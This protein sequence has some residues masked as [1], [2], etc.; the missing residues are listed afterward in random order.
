MSMLG[1]IGYGYVGRSVEYGFVDYDRQRG[2]EP[3]HKALIHDKYKS[4]LSL[5]EVAD[6]SEIIFLCLPTP[7]DEERLRIDLSITD[8]VLA[9][10]AP[11][12]AG[13]GKIIVIKS[14][15]VPGTT[16]RYAGL[17]PGVPF[18]MNPEFLTEANY[19]QDFVKPDRIV[20]GVDN[21]WVGQKL[22]DLYRTCFPATTIMRMSTA[23]AEIVKYQA[24][25]MLASKV[26]LANVFYDL[27]LAQ[28]VNYE[29]VKK[30][31]ALDSRI[32]ASHLDVTTERGFGGK[33]FPKDLGAIIGRC[34]ELG[35][36]AGA[37]EEI[38]SYNLR[39]RK[40]R[41]WHEIAGAMVG[42]RIYGDT[43][44]TQQ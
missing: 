39:I 38:H 41:D 4:S 32:G 23:A 26:A 31:V 19:L 37:L 30:G 33:C 24:N 1:I 29:D 8:E 11:R 18:A 9:F 27:C 3:K 40:V 28:G 12:I 42:G 17:Y 10:I 21:D 14:T 35:V 2:Y 22:I 5:E 7:Y 20:L 25:V 44:K 15:V 16:R 43:P 13:Q 34:R 36:D 6:K